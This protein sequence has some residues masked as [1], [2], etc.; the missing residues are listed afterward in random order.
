MMVLETEMRRMQIVV[1]QTAPNVSIQK[2]VMVAPTARVG[3]VHPKSAK[4]SSS[5][6]TVDL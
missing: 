4:V 5:L 6:N 3:C 2:S 1:V